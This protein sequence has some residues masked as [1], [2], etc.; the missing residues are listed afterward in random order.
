MLDFQRPTTSQITESTIQVN[1]FPG[2]NMVAHYA[3]LITTFFMLEHRDEVI[4]EMLLPDPMQTAEYLHTTN[5]GLIGDTDIAII[6]DVHHLQK[7]WRGEWQGNSLPE[8]D[9][10][11]WNKFT[12]RNNKTVALVGCVEKIWGDTGY[13][14]MRTM[15][16]RSRIKCAIYVGKA[17]CLSE[18]YSPNEWIATG[19]QV[20]LEDKIIAFQNPLETACS[21]SNLV[22]SGPIVT[23]ATTLCETKQW[24]E[25][26]SS[27]AVWVDCEVGYFARAAAEL[28]I[29]FGFL[30]VVSDNLCHQG[31]ENLSNEELDIVTNRAKL[32]SGLK[33][34]V[35][36]LHKDLKR[37]PQNGVAWKETKKKIAAWDSVGVVLLDD[38][39]RQVYNWKV[40][41][42][43]IKSRLNDICGERWK[44]MDGRFVAWPKTHTV[45]S[46]TE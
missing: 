33:D 8:I 22:A 5:V 18:E 35:M 23:V 38:R 6:G 13:E 39:N 40:D 46:L 16:Q 12:T 26:W 27:K 42:G 30:H 11:R 20:F 15:H 41:K 37:Q 44:A 45:T 19:N 24:V 4:V 17:G 9:I 1:C 2:R 28:D 7:L 32:V 31:G 34:K 29:D 36:K 3:S 25:E 10:F 14:L 21:T 43:N